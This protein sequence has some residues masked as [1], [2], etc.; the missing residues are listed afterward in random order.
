VVKN[1]GERAGADVVQLYVRD[2]AGSVTRPVKE[3]KAFRR[4]ALDPGAEEI[5][6]FDVPVE[7]LGFW[8]LDMRYGVEPG[9]F[10]LWLGPSSNEGLEGA[11][12]VRDV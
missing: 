6:R 11:F 4:V 2:L 5:V 12:E 9:S 7:Q 3:L 10:K 1:T 8:G